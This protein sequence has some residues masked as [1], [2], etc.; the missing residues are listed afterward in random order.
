MDSG[1]GL[2]AK[3]GRNA[4]RGA[5]FCEEHMPSP[6][7]Q[8]QEKL[9]RALRCLGGLCVQLHKMERG[10]DSDRVASLSVTLRDEICFPRPATGTPPFAG[11]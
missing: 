9:D 1:F 7:E 3:C 4:D 2:C 8:L 11:Y 5:N 10:S 6:E